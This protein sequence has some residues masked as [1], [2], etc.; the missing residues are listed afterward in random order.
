ML[1][2]LLQ[3]E[4]WR[5]QLDCNFPAVQAV[6]ADCMLEATQVLGP[7]GMEAYVDCA[8]ALGK[9]GR[10]P[11]P[12]LALLQEWP[13]VAHTVGSAAAQDLLAD[14]AALLTAMQ[15]SPNSTAMA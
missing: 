3:I 7:A 9:M 8:R 5:K 6:F 2:S 14:V 12:V 11:E 15:K 13:Q 1:C 10:G 4:T